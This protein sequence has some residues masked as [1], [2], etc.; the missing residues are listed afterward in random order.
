MP[1][2]KRK[3]P[4]KR[5]KVAPLPEPIDTLLSIPDVMRILGVSRR[6]V[7]NLIERECLPVMRVGKSVRFVPLSFR[8]WMS[9]RERIA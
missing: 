3:Q 4:M 5:V 1:T 8:Q 9:E 7:Y 6:T 2:R